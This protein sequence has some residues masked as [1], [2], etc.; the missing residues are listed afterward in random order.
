MP[1][2]FSNTPSGGSGYTPYVRY[3]AGTASWATAEGSFQFTKAA[4]DF[5]KIRTGWCYLAQGE[6]PDWVLDANL[7]NRAPKP[8]GDN[9]KRGFRLNMMSKDMFGN[10]EPVREWATSSAGATLAIQKLYDDW[11]QMNPNENQVAVVTFSG[12]T[13][14]K[15]GKGSTNVPILKIEKLIDRPAELAEISGIGIASQAPVST[16]PSSDD[17]F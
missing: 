10:D 2:S 14:T 6:A 13:P 4:F 11:E 17:E 1:L 7:Q 5:G 3:M 16:A 15:V 12:A 8:D 9:W